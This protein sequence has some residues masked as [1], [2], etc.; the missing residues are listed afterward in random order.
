LHAQRATAPLRLRRSGGRGWVPYP[1]ARPGCLGLGLVSRRIGRACFALAASSAVLRLWCQVHSSLRL[2][3]SWF[4]PAARFT[5]W[6]TSEP[7][8]VQPSSCWHI[9]AALCM[10]RARVCFQPG[11]SLGRR[12]E[13]QLCDIGGLTFARLGRSRLLGFPR[14]RV[15]PS[16]LLVSSVQ[17]ICAYFTVL[18]V[19]T[20]RLCAYATVCA[21]YTLPKL[22]PATRSRVGS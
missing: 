7:L 20:L 22:H 13:S 16:K 15:L 19:Y 21:L 9:P 3:R 14:V 4:P 5:I 12:L 18:G 2:F 10:T 11:G 6:S 1:Y 17:F 8:C